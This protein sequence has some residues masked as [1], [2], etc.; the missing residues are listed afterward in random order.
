MTP[1]QIA[2][3][4]QEAALSPA[5]LALIGKLIDAIRGAPDPMRAVKRATI[6]AG[7]E[8]ASTETIRRV[9]KAKAKK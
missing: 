3:K 8:Q 7:S 2:K 4:L 9:L 5:G 6:A 1:A